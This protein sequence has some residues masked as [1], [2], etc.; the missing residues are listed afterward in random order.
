MANNGTK[1]PRV[2]LNTADEEELKLLE[3]ISE[4]RARLIIEHRKKHGPFKSWEEFEGIQGIGPIL[5]EKARQV[6][7]LGGGSDLEGA[8]PVVALEDVEVL[9]T[10][11]RLDLE[12]AL[13]YETGAE[14]VVEVPDVREQLLRFRDDHLRHVEDLNQLIVARGGPPIQSQPNPSLYLLRSLALISQPFGPVALVLTLLTNEQMT[15]GTYDLTR[16]FDWDDEVLRVLERNASD[17]QRHLQWLVEKE[18]ELSGP[19]ELPAAPA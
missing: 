5:T 6:A 16:E 13:A 18:E 14:A 3:G 12:A 1:Q 11:A 17:E 15:N 2:D 9:S 10:L 19:M 7:V 4:E 8:A